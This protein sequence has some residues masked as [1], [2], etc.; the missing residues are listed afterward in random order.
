MKHLHYYENKNEP[1]IGDYV[2]CEDT[3]FSK[4]DI[5]NFI[6]NNVG[7]IIRIRIDGDFFIKYKNIPQ[8]LISCFDNSGLALMFKYEILHYSKDEEYLKQLL[9]NKKFNI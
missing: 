8:N 9:I 6:E 7:Q 4:E 3:Y 1:Q 2:I 5:H